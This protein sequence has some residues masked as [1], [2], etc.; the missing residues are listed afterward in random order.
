[1]ADLAYFPFYPER[2][3]ADPKVQALTLEERGAYHELLAAMWTYESGTCALPNDDRFLGR[4]LGVSDRRWKALRRA[5]ISGPSSPIRVTEDGRWL[6][7]DFLLAL[8]AKA[9]DKS[10]KSRAAVGSRHDRRDTDVLRTINGRSTDVDRTYNGRPTDD[11]PPKE[12][13]PR[14]VSGNPPTPPRGGRARTSSAMA[15]EATIRTVK[16]ISALLDRAGLTARPDRWYQAACSVTYK[17]LRAKRA[18]P[19]D[20]LAA[21]T[22][23]LGP[24]HRAFHATKLTTAGSIPNAVAA[25]QAAM[26]ANGHGAAD[27]GD[28]DMPNAN[29]FEYVGNPRRPTGPGPPAPRANDRKPGG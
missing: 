6:V 14:E 27:A 19:D 12:P 10:A 29:T 9:V 23:C 22:W 18:G 20:I 15:D 25:W 16:S 11:V 13:D 7:S 2:W 17:L 3:R 26:G 28:P 21:A 8:H 4:L 1:M 5:L 24:E